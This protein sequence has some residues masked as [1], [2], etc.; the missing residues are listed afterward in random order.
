MISIP[1]KIHLSRLN[2][3]K[4]DSYTQRSIYRAM[5]ASE[6]ARFLK[7]TLNVKYF[8][9]CIICLSSVMCRKSPII[10]T[11]ANI[12]DKS[13]L[14]PRPYERFITSGVPLPRV[15]SEPIE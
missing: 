8:H 7:Q 4:T 13:Y 5:K 10:H 1:P 11:I 9:E 6:N 2:G 15:S 12:A 3:L 14:D